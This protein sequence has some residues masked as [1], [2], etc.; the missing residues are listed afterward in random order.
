MK[1][2]GHRP[3]FK[4][5]AQT[6]IPRHRTN[7]RQWW[8]VIGTEYLQTDAR[9][10]L[11][12]NRMDITV[13]ECTYIETTRPDRTGP[14]R[15]ASGTPAA[16]PQVHLRQLL[17]INKRLGLLISKRKRTGKPCAI[18]SALVIQCIFP[19]LNTCELIYSP[20]CTHKSQCLPT[21]NI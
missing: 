19:L 4:D 14:T 16:E 13:P 15:P 8:S 6:P 1:T 2:E 21:L 17:P 7:S 20:C 9:I 5:F 12:R 3:T 18:C 11:L 10:A